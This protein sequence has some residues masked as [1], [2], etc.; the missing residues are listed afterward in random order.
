MVTETKKPA[1]TRVYPIT[2]NGKVR[3]IE[4]TSAAAAVVHAFRP[5]VGAPLTGAQ[6]A[7][8]MRAGGEIEQVSA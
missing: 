3:N 1:T 8:V 4:A 5:S 6:V 7:A 2:I